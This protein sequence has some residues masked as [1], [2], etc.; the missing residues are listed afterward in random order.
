M[1]NK[2]TLT[3]IVSRNDTDLLSNEL[4]DDLVIMDSE[5]GNYIGL[6]KTAHVIWKGIEHPITVKELAESLVKRYDIKLD[7]CTTDTIQYLE[8]ML[9][10]NLIKL[11]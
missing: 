3:T 9:S 2:I 1:A 8:S 10:Q 7:Q 5:S 4:G 6:N 11:S